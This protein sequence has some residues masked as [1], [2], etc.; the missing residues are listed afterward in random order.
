MCF[1]NSLALLENHS[2]SSSSCIDQ[3]QTRGDTCRRPEKILLHPVLTMLPSV[4]QERGGLQIIAK[5]KL[6]AVAEIVT[7]FWYRA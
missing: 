7:A 6:G 4:Q 3:A 2:L 5:G 1:F